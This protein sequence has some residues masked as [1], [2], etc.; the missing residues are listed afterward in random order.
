VRGINI[1]NDDHLP[2]ALGWPRRSFGHRRRPFA[3]EQRSHYEHSGK[4]AATRPPD[5]VG[6]S[7][8]SSV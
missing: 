5:C 7:Y 3:K 2:L 8:H 1:G 6:Q 4:Q